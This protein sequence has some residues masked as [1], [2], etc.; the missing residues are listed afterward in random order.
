[1]SGKLPSLTPIAGLPDLGYSYLLQVTEEL[2]YVATRRAPVL[3][4]NTTQLTIF[5]VSSPDRPQRL[6]SLTVPRL[7]CFTVHNRHAYAGSRGGIHIIDLTVIQQPVL[8]GFIPFSRANAAEYAYCIALVGDVAVVAA[9][10]EGM[11]VLDLALPGEPKLL[12]TYLPPSRTEVTDGRTRV[13]P[14][15]VQHVAL[16]P[17]HAHVSELMGTVYAVDMGNLAQ[18]REVARQFVGTAHTMRYH[19]QC[20][21]IATRRPEDRPG[22]F[23]V[24]DVSTPDEPR[25]ISGFD[26]LDLME[27]LHFVGTTAFSVGGTPGDGDLQAR[28]ELLH[29][30]DVSDARRPVHLGAYPISAWQVA[31]DEAVLY[32]VGA[33]GLRIYAIH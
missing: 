4:D 28:P 31:G 32:A 6:G 10:R 19:N 1:M 23:F 11:L 20:L 3:L 25:I 24:V 18:P 21:Y 27:D 9:G 16:G 17:W 8:V 2:A 7:S 26:T 15:W 12:S 30:W 13:R 29:G 5:D 22:P 33:G 14:G